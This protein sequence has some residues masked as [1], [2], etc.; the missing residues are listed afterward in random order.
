MYFEYL[1]VH[2]NSDIEKYTFF[3]EQETFTEM[4]ESIVRRD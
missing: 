3:R 1:D 4:G 2:R